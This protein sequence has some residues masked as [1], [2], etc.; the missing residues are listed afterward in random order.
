MIDPQCTSMSET[1]GSGES[2]WNI[3]TDKI[4]IVLNALSDVDIDSHHGRDNLYKENQETAIISSDGV[5]LVVIT[6]SIDGFKTEQT[7]RIQFRV[8]KEGIESISI[9]DGDPWY[10]DEA[11]EHGDQLYE[12]VVEELVSRGWVN[13]EDRLYFSPIE[14]KSDVT[15]I[16]FSTRIQVPFDVLY[17]DLVAQPAVSI[18]VQTQTVFTDPSND[19][20]VAKKNV[21]LYSDTDLPPDIT[22]PLNNI[23]SENDYDF[24][25][26]NGYDIETSQFGDVDYDGPLGT[27]VFDNDG[28]PKIRLDNDTRVTRSIAHLLMTGGDENWELD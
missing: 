7:V 13:D 21:D 25:S 16:V 19:V 18:N 17:P 6:D 4:N 26:V 14:S 3:Y 28:V 8:P 15:T 27:Y 23:G 5:Q 22:F 12:S 1:N 2:G 10:I 20:F 11:Y 9:A 24:K